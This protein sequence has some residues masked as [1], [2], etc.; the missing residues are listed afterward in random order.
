MWR[1]PAVSDRVTG[2]YAAVSN[3][4]GSVAAQIGPRHAWNCSGSRMNR[5]AGY[6]VKKVRKTASKTRWL[7]RSTVGPVRSQFSNATAIALWNG[8]TR[9]LTK[10]CCVVAGNGTTGGGGSTG[11]EGGSG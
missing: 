8:S 2:M 7:T 1:W 10:N 4:E 5:I 6:I 9:T 3:L 11:A